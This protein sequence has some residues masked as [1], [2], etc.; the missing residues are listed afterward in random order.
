MTWGNGA[1]VSADYV[2]QEDSLVGVR[3]NDLNGAAV[4]ALADGD[5]VVFSPNWSQGILFGAGAVTLLS[6]SSGVSGTI[7]S[8][9]SV[10]GQKAYAGGSP[11]F[12]YDASRH[13]LAVGRPAE[14]IVTLLS[15]DDIFSDGFEG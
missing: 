1:G 6:G 10:I 5:Y 13:R 12:S 2:S 3:T 11:N 4:T 9:N 14:N 7:Q 15:I 8:R